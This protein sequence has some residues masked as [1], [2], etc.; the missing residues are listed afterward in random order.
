MKKVSINN[1]VV[2]PRSAREVVMRHAHMHHRG[3]SGT[4]Q[5]IKLRCY[6]PNCALDV[7]QMVCR[8]SV[9]LEKHRVDLHDGEAFDR[10]TT[11]V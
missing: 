8:C 10:G 9:C 4:L 11:K 5:E 2:V 3:M 6:W 7:A 1:Q